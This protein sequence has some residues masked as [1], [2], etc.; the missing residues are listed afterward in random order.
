M[1]RDRC[2]NF[3]RA[4]GVRVVTVPETLKPLAIPAGAVITA[5]NGVGVRDATS[6]L[7]T[8]TQL[9]QAGKP[10]HKLMIELLVDG[11]ARAIE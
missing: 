2:L 8:L 3:L 7:A 11:E 6:L 4:R 1:V 5:V 10:P 9:L